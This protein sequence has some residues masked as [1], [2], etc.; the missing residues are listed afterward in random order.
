MPPRL[1]SSQL[2]EIHRRLCDGDRT[3]S[4]ELA[5][6]ILDALM[7][8]ISRQFP[9]SDEDMRYEAVTKALLD[10]CAQPHRFAVERGVPLHHFLLMASRYDML[11][12]LRGEARRKAREEEAGHLHATIAVELDPVVGNLL[13][14]EENEQR[15]QLEEEM[16]SLLQDPKDRQIL[17][18]RLQGERRT[19]AFAEILG[20]SHLPI[21][22]QR[23]G[24]KR[25][26]DRID[27]ILR[28]HGGRT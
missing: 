8:G 27:K 25:A 13:Q 5:E 9:R 15:H 22:A 20:I 28:R 4:E 21:E 2:L 3:A 12:L 10:Y 19:E 24:V 17:A 18:L 14:K 1:N 6:L 16:M 23:R 26:K 11:N 7:Q